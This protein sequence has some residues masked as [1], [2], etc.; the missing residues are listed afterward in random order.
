MAGNKTGDGLA[1]RRAGSYVSNTGTEKRHPMDI[2]LELSFH[3]VEPYDV[4]KQ[5]V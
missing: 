3:N 4:I 5:S 2:P 1:Q